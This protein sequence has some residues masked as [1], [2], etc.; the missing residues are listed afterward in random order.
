LKFKKKELEKLGFLTFE[1]QSLSQEAAAALAERDLHK[2]EIRALLLSVKSNPEDYLKD[3]SLEPLAILLIERAKPREK[4]SYK[5][6]IPFQTWG[7][8]HE[9]EVF[10]QMKRACSLPISRF[11]ALMADAHLGYGLPI[12]GVLATHDAVIPYAVGIDIG[13]RV[14]ITLLDYPLVKFNKDLHN[15]KK[16]LIECTQFGMGSHFNEPKEH[17]VLDQDW[18][19]SPLV[20]TLK[21]LARRQLGTSGSGNHFVEFGECQLLE[22]LLGL[23]PNTYVALVSHSGSR[24]P[25]AQVANYYTRLAKEQCPQLGGKFKELA[26]LS[27]KSA[28]GIEYWR[29][30]EL[31]GDFASANHDVIHRELLRYL[32][33]KP[34]ISIENHHNFAWKEEHNGERLIVHRKGATPAGKGVLGYIPGTM[35]DP[36]FIVSGCGKGESLNSASHGAGRKM[37]RSRARNTTTRHELNTILNERRVSLISA[38][39]DESPL[40]YKSIDAVMASQSD[41]VKVLGKFTP[42]IVKMAPEGEKP[43][44]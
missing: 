10:D 44:D 42:R 21:D 36:G 19:F 13:C 4:T 6:P 43:E 5:D 14:K 31:M 20:K 34:L 38:G 8:D 30:M 11:G 18:S 25:G 41:L 16:A 1:E 28:E 37:S 29:S 17:E 26:W 9:S 12:G 3:E 32:K 35:A 39:L 33:I 40:A 15:F 27:L 24:G 2:G 23:T 7:S 22:S